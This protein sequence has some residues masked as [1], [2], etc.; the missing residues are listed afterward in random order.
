[1]KIDFLACVSARMDFCCRVKIFLRSSQIIFSN[2]E[3]PENDK[4]GTVL[5]CWNG[6]ITQQ[7]YLLFGFLSPFLDN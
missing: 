7:L 5:R 2:N 1:M 3:A 4:I 6:L